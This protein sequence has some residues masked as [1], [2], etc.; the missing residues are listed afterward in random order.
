MLQSN[1]KIEVMGLIWC[2]NEE[3]NGLDLKGK[4]LKKKKEVKH[5]SEEERK[6]RYKE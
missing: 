1:I 4:R 6:G 3:I 5:V 2:E